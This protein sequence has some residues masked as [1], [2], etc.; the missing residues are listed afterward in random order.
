MVK[1]VMCKGNE[2][3]VGGCT[4]CTPCKEKTRSLYNGAPEFADMAFISN[5]WALVPFPSLLKARNYQVI[6]I[7]SHKHT[8]GR[9]ETTVM[10]KNYM[11]CS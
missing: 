7:N 9:E 1:G 4:F 6:N 11:Y 5:P 3:G 8:V 10:E 2:A